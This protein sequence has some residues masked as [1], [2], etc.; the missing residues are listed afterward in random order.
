M[1]GFEVVTATGGL[2]AWHKVQQSPP[3]LVITDLMMPG[4]NGLALCRALKA[5]S[6]LEFIPIILWTAAMI[7]VG[8]PVFDRF[9]VKPVL[10]D[11]LLEH[12]RVLLVGP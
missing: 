7:S 3:A 12:I 8:E 11:T 5:D 1:E 6:R 9:L 2:D 10:L 4:M